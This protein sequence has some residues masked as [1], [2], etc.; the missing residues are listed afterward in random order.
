MDIEFHWIF[1]L[2]LFRWSCRISPLVILIGVFDVKLLL[3]SWDKSYFVTFL[4]PTDWFYLLTFSSGGLHRS[5]FV[6]ESSPMIFL[7]ST[8]FAWFWCKDYTSLMQVIQGMVP[9][10]FSEV[11]CV[12]L[13]WSLSWVFDISFLWDHIDIFFLFVR[14]KVFIQYL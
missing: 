12:M 11:V 9:L 14:F 8:L 7:P 6:S 3:N 10:L 1:F 4:I 5:V 2:Y 13:D